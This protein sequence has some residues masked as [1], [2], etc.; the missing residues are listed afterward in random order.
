MNFT[1]SLSEGTNGANINNNQMGN[2]LSSPATESGKQE[3]DEPNHA[4]TMP[5]ASKLP[6]PIADKR[7]FLTL[8]LE[9]RLEIYRQC[10]SFTLLQLYQTHPQIRAELHENPSIYNRSFGFRKISYTMFKRKTYPTY[11][12]GLANIVELWDRAELELATRLY[13]RAF[14]NGSS[15]FDVYNWCSDCFQN[16]ETYWMI[17]TPNGIPDFFNRNGDP[18]CE[19]ETT[20]RRGI[21]EQLAARRAGTAQYDRAE[22]EKTA[23][24]VTSDE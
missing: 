24:L 10:P 1:P 11:P 16:V 22:G 20:M 14:E 19:C 3:S 21:E 5:S 7:T 6:V 15:S 17:E 12:F 8:P 23:T 9:M 4:A 18:E 2:L 13:G